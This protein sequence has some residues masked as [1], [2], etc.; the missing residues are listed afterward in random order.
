MKERDND[1]PS[2]LGLRREVTWDG[3]KQTQRQSA[4]ESVLMGAC[5]C[6]CVWVCHC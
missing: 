5:T 2:V 6:V 4:K 3:Q 1:S